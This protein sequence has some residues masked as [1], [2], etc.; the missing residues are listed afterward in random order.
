MRFPKPPLAM[1]AGELSHG[2]RP[3]DLLF[4]PQRCSAKA[5]WLPVLSAR[6]GLFGPSFAT[7][8]PSGGVLTQTVVR[9]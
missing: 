8:H 3:S 9:R 4:M 2:S 6:R 5:R 1:T 7:S